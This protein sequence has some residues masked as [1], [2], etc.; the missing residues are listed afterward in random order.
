M[1]MLKFAS[2]A[3]LLAV[4][5]VVSLAVIHPARAKS[6]DKTQEGGDNKVLVTGVPQGD[7]DQI[8]P[9]GSVITGKGNI[10][11]QN[12]IV[13][14]YAPVGKISQVYLWDPSKGMI[15]LGIVAPNS[16]WPDTVINAASIP[17]FAGGQGTFQ[18]QGMASPQGAA[19]LNQGGM[20]SGGTRSGY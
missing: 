17:Q 9:Q 8:F 7:A 15:L 1:K 6:P 3:V 10:P 11:D 2:L 14:S 12:G 5:L 19:P 4:A 13:T 18:N 20:Q 16:T